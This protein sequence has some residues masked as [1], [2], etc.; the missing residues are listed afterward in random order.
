MASTRLTQQKQVPGVGGGAI[1]LQ[2]T[3][4]HGPPGSAGLMLIFMHASLLQTTC[5]V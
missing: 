5:R 3:G 1:A 2:P 4:P